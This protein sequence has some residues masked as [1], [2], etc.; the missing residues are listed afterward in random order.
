MKV[1]RVVKSL[2]LMGRKEP[3]MATC[4]A[5]GLDE[6]LVMTFEFRGYEF[7]CMNCG[8]KYDFL[9]PVPAPDTPELGAKQIERQ[10]QYDAERAARQPG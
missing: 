9:E 3:P 7:I 8:G 4:P 2:D 5:C 1:D 10:K 6:P